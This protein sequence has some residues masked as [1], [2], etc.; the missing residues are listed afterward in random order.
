VADP[1]RDKHVVITG[2]SRGLGRAL[3]RSFHARG[4]RVSLFARASTEVEALR[5]ELGERCAAHAGDIRRAADRAAALAHFRSR[6]GPI[7]ALVNNAGVGAYEPFL[8]NTAE[9]IEDTIATNFTALVLLTHAVAAEMVERRRGHLVHVASDLGR[10]P[11]ANMAVYTATKHA[12]VGFSQSL[13]RELRTHGV[14]STVVNPGIIDTAFGGNVEGSR[15][16]PGALAS[17]ELAAL[18]VDAVA[19][20]PHLLVDELSVHA[21]GQDF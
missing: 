2:A 15:A 17:A 13:A 3:A 4:A 20:P 10:R 6:H 11:L 8:T 14:K 9:A 19:M 18:I 5:Q 21:L 12:V 7:D 16:G 1:L